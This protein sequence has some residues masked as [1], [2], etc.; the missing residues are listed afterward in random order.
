MTKQTKQTKVSEVISRGWD[1]NYNQYQEYMVMNLK[2]LATELIG[3]YD[4]ESVGYSVGVALL[5]KIGLL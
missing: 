3:T 2:S 1:E 4:T 5:D